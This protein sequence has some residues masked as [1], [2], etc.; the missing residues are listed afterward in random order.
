MAQPLVKIITYQHFFI[1]TKLKF[2][3]F[4]EI[5]NIK[6]NPLLLA[7][8]IYIGYFLEFTIHSSIDQ[9]YQTIVK[10]IPAYHSVVRAEYILFVGRGGELG[11]FCMSYINL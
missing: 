6:I 5:S 10:N 1:S 9:T 4:V 11:S 7:V 8:M 3:N 2:C